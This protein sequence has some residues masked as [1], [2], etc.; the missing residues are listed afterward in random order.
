MKSNTPSIIQRPKAAFT[1]VELLVVITII[2]ILI[3]LLLPAVQAAREAARKAQ[4][5]NNF[6]QVG[7]A[8]HLYHEQKNCF[9]PGMFDP[10]SRPGAPYW[11][12]WSAYI[13]P[14][15]EQAAIYD[16]YDFT[17]PKNYSSVGNNRIA[18][19]QFIK[20]YLCPS[21]PQRGEWL[22]VSLGWQYGP[23]PNDD[24][25]M[26]NMAAVGDSVNCFYWSSSGQW[27]PKLFSD[28]DGMFGANYC[29]TMA[30]VKDGTSHTLMIGEVT[31]EG[32][33]SG[34][35]FF[36]AAD[37]ML[38]TAYG[39]NGF[40]TVIGGT[41]PTITQGGFYCSGPSSYHPGGCH[42][43]LADGSSQFISQNIAAT[44]LAALTTRDGG[45][46]IDGNAVGF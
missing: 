14:Q 4:C 31:G 12:S 7:I 40:T 21:D 10:R 20:P 41:Y 29:C 37:N 38:F 25:A 2:G 32:P 43:T 13:L 18:S 5:M 17:S 26:G 3:A 42:F 33:G 44:V 16:M 9:P 6:R 46:V 23:K 8:L 45:E 24:S 28:V 19:A 22:H 34:N 39:I 1:L 11:W 15:L 35:G 27:W 30:D 36:W